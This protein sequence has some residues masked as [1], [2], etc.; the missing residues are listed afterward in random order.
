[1]DQS[2]QEVVGYYQLARIESLIRLS[3]SS[4]ENLKE[5]LHVLSMQRS[6]QSAIAEIPAERRSML[7]D[8]LVNQSQL[9]V[10]LAGSVSPEL[11]RLKFVVSTTLQGDQAMD[12]GRSVESNMQ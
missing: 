10:S 1:M 3:L 2:L 8:S 12:T 7:L 4:L 5:E 11:G 9:L 6:R